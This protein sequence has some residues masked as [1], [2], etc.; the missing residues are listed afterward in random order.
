MVDGTRNDGKLSRSVWS[1][2]KAGDDFKRLP[3]ATLVE[4]ELL[5]LLRKLGGFIEYI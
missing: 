5:S 4:E 3:I 1:R 2:G